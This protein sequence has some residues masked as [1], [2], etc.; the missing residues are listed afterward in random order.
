MNLGFE[1]IG[2]ALL[3]TTLAGFST[4]IGSTIAYF[5]K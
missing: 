1:N 4:G 3:F 2:V 5:I